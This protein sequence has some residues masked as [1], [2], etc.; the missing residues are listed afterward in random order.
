MS[1]HDLLIAMNEKLDELKKDFENHLQEH[2]RYMYMAWSTGI[3]LIITLIVML[4]K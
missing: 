2:K 1:D 3:G 4:L